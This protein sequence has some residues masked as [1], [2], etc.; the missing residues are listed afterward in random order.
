M[1]ESW[2]ILSESNDLEDKE[3]MSE[4]WESMRQHPEIAKRANGPDDFYDIGE[5]FD[6]LSEYQET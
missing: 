5:M 1:N 6:L 2:K 3:V 4:A